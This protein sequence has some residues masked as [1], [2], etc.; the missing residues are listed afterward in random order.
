MRERDVNASV[1]RRRAGCVTPLALLLA[2]CA[3]APR[4]QQPPTIA[5]LPTRT[6]LPGGAASAVLP[7]PDA[8]RAMTSYQQFLQMQNAD[9]ALRAEA[10]RRLADLKLESGEL[11][12]MSNEVS[13]VDAP[14][15]DAIKLYTTLLQ[16]YPDYPRN[17]QVLY[18]LARAYDTTGQEAQALATLDRIVARYPHDPDIGEVQFRRGELLF[19]MQHYAQAQ[20]AYEAVLALG[21]GG[22]SFYAQSLYKRGWA[23]F[24][25]GLN[26]PSLQTFAD[27]LDLTLVDPAAGGRVRGL[28]QL[29][30]AD[31]E[32]VD[33]TLRVMSIS[34]SYLDG[35]G[36]ITQLKTQ[37]GRLPYAWLLYQ[38]LGD[39][40]VSKQRYQDAA[41]TYRAFV[42]QDA[43][44]EHAPALS[45]AAIAAYRKGGFPE[46]MLQAKLEY[47]Q[48]YGF[49]SPFWQGRTQDAYPQVVAQLQVN[50]KD[51]AE[52]YHALAQ[53]KHDDADYAAAA[54]WY[55]AYLTSFPHVADAAATN[56]LL[57]DAL[58][59]SHQ[60]LQAATEYEHTAYD[61]PAHR[62]AADAGYAALV[63]WQDYEASLPASARAAVHA[64]A[65]DSS[66]KF[67]QT[68]PTHPASAG[69]LTRAAQ[70]LYAAGNQARATQT[71]QRLLRQPGATA[72]QQRIALSIVGQVSAN[73]GN[74]AGAEQAFTRALALVG[75]SDPERSDLNERLAATIYQ[76][77]DRKRAAGDLLGAADDFLRV[78]RV[79]AGSK[80]VA[81]AQYDAAAVLIDA[82][83]WQSAIPILEAYRRDYPHSQYTPGVGRKLAV[84]YAAAGQAGPAAAEFERIAAN[85]NE[86]PDVVREALTRAADLY[87]QAGN[88]TRATAMLEQLV[89]RFP[90]PIPDA[91][92]ARARLLQLA[93]QQGDTA[94]ALFWQRQIVK[95]D[96][97]AGAARTDRTRYLAAEA[98]LALAAPLR[99]EFRR[100]RLT[101]P[102]K[103]SLAAKSRALQAAVQAY[104][105]VAAYQV[106]QTTTAATFETA[107]LYHRLAEDLLA[108]ERPRRLSAAER[109][110]YESLLEDQAY[111]FEEQ[112]ISI[113]EINAQRVQSG[114]YDDSIRAS[115]SALAQLLP[116]RYGK[117]ERTENWIA[118]LTAPAPAP[119]AAAAPAAAPTAGNDNRP[120]VPPPSAAALA[121]F[122]HATDL[123]N[124]GKN[125]DAQ[126]ELQQF[127]LRYPGYAVPEI[128]RGLLARRD[129]QLAQSEQALQHA[130]QLDPQSAVAWSEL[131]V[132]LRMEG[133]FKDARKA[134]EQAVTLEPGYAPAHRNLGVLLDMYLGDPVAALPQL[135]RYQMLT[136]EGKPV[137]TWIA[138]LRQRT[139]QKSGAAPA[140]SVPT[141]KPD[142][143][144][145]ASAAQLP[146]RNASAPTAA[147][148]PAG[149]P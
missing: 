3:T 41:A 77:G 39:L 44:D 81:T 26:E 135:E 54:R 93:Q 29:A 133:K 36:S 95:T 137:S 68:F 63:A 130:T 84:A 149:T 99:D 14:A 55:R 49:D 65:I 125:A 46:L 45:M 118:A 101:T 88:R 15:A 138:D 100:I 144:T 64:R 97:E 90:T 117:T 110:Q 18:Q 108:S 42:A 70:D 124:A 71:A 66:L 122:Q 78:G 7:G 114:L 105:E 104:K 43:V 127:E 75:P 142:A 62:Q 2:A 106:A 92:E 83:Q 85:P 23:Q 145:P 47:V 61:Y 86:E 8:S 59:E 148:M 57:A 129:G 58:F 132:T 12:R 147:L 4:V 146:A 38:R 16:A 72:A 74:S 52:Y 48:R 131:G 113:H 31:H 116:A 80:I 6:E 136:G 111:P 24:K 139:G 56:Y 143:Q 10:M 89:K 69:V 9:P 30:R 120:S 28:E 27:L 141:A 109:E 73:Q 32:L 37:R 5:D 40:Y 79:A 50:L 21:R 119:E 123:A 115:M 87:E 134:Y 98:Q 53:K 25:Q 121:D 94:R 13:R 102:L 82:K 51:V 107:E 112:A 20:Q 17:D 19:S 60:Y 140:A 33:D 11:E 76:Q 128:D 67:A 96:A 34:F 35:A 126:L 91:I 22:S 103:R 1:C